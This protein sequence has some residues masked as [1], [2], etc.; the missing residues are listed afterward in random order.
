VNLAPPPEL[1][2]RRHAGALFQRA[3]QFPPLRT[4][5]AYPTSAQALVATVEAQ[6]RGLLEPVLVGP[7]AA[8]ERAAAEARV[9]L[10]GCEFVDTPQGAN[11]AH[12]A[13]VTAVR[14][15]REGDVGAVMK[16]SLHTEDLLRPVVARHDGL[17]I[18]GHPRRLSH[19]FWIDVP[20]YSRP[21]LLTDC[22]IN[23]TPTLGTKCDI[24][25]NAIDLARLLGIAQPK[26]AVVSATENVN[27]SIRSTLDGQA[28]AQMA[29]RGEIT[30]GLVDG[31]FG[32]DLAVSPDAVLAKGIVSAVAGQAD[33]VL[34]P[35]LEAGN[36]VY[37]ALVYLADALCAGIVLG[38]RVPVILTSRA[39][40]IDSR[41]AS[42]AL[43]VIQANVRADDPA[44]APM[45]GR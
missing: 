20:Q 2:A 45:A 12:E 35:D 19:V 23:V 27:A 7:S 40:S 32:F 14:L 9:Q 34:L 18:P 4:A 41:L 36:I 5:V 39:D 44:A 3:R 30:G 15:A 26:L 43:A 21:L 31:P 16:G 42:C 33:I 10:A 1:T 29:A 38:T 6:R 17:R 13:A 37:K 11:E 24:A 28:L 25:Q 8:I 22:V